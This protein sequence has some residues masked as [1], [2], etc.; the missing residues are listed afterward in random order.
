[1]ET[2]AIAQQDL[3]SVD[4][5]RMLQTQGNFNLEYVIQKRVFEFFVH[6]VFSLTNFVAL[7]FHKTFTSFI[8]YFSASVQR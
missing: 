2:H 1:M 4:K 5:L 7:Y 8:F 3:V 6:L